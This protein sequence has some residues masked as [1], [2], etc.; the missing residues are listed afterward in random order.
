MMRFR[1]LAGACAAVVALALNACAQTGSTV[2]EPSEA[3]APLA[4][5]GPAP[6]P[7]AIE[8][9]PYRSVTEHSFTANGETVSYTAI[10][11]DTWLRDMNGE[12]T[13]SVFS[14]TYLRTDVQDARRPVVFVFNGGPGS[15]SLWIHMGAIGP[16]RV[17]LD[18][19]VNPSNVPPF[20]LEDNPNSILDVA[21][22][23]FIDPVGTG[24]SVPLKGTDPKTFWGVDEDAESIAQFIELWLSEHGRWNSPKYILGESYGSIR[25]AVLPRALMGSP[26]YTGLMRGITLDGIV[27]LG[28]TLDARQAGGAD[29]PAGELAAKQA[30]SLPGIAATSAFHGLVNM[31]AEGVTAVYKAAEAYARE[32]Y[33]PALRQHLAGT[34]TP[35][36]RAQVLQ[37]LSRMT[38]LAES[39]IGDDLYI[40]ERS[41]AKAALRG[42]GLE[43]GM[44]DSRY[45][46]PLANSGGD[47]V[48]DD[49]AM[50]RYVPGFIASFQQMIRDDLNVRLG[51]P[52]ASI[53]WRELLFGWNWKRK[54]VAEG[55]SYATDLA[56]AMRRNPDLRVMV[57]SGYYDLVTTPADAR[58][59]IAAAGLPQDRVTFTDYASGHMLYL[60][61]TSEAFSSDLRDFLE[62]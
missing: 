62:K 24:F 2:S 52:Y 20:G 50:T 51:R 30:R 8:P 33:E 26:I 15:A 21:D 16:R 54:G 23:V 5:E 42:R 46:L 39:E 36:A 17:V 3:P 41:Y 27:L 29:L 37:D 4:A 55:Q 14:F 28:T 22:L 25:A 47:P 61:G 10:A 59:S 13:A 48:A 57:A 34:L 40:D 43:V 6:E 18:A 7:V 58:A 45:T 60:G 53:R 9:A 12:P 31:P 49:P 38:G 44:Y 19:D 32:S 11:G 35:Q 1:L 56:W